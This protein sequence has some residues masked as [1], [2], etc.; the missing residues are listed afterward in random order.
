[1]L[2]D[3]S[4]RNLTLRQKFRI[5]FAVLVCVSLI[6]FLVLRYLGKIALF[7]HL[8][9]EHRVA[10]WQIRT[11]L[12]ALE[13]QTS[14]ARGVS[15]TQLL[16]RLESAGAVALRG[17]FQELL[18]IERIVLSAVR[19]AEFFERIATDIAIGERMM[20]VIRSEP[21][22]A[23]SVTTAQALNRQLNVRFENSDRFQPLLDQLVREFRVITFFVTALGLALLF[24]VG[25]LARR[26]ILNPVAEAVG[27]AA[28]VSDG[29][30]RANIEV[31]SADEIGQLQAALRKMTSGLAEL[32]HDV[33]ST[34]ASVAAAA[35]ELMAGSNNLSDR[36]QRQAHA[37]ER[38]AD[39]MEQLSEAV[40]MN[41]AHARRASETAER[42]SVLATEGSASVAK[43][44]E[45]MKAISSSSQRIA[46]I[47]AIMDSI[48][49]QTNILALNAAVEAARAGA[50]GRGFA[51]VAAEVRAL[52][53]RSSAAAREIK[54]LID[55]SSANVRIGNNL[56]AEAGTKIDVTADSIRQVSALVNDIS[57]ASEQQAGN[58][59][60][61]KQDVVQ[62]DSVAQQNAA[63][64]EQTAAAVAAQTEQARYLVDSVNR[65]KL[66]GE[67]AGATNA[68]M[69]GTPAALP[70]R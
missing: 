11:D 50:Q 35:R 70:R 39:R 29:D 56:V 24:W 57:A 55:T 32:V 12:N 40:R 2:N 54:Q 42:A 58:I 67:D 7:Y 3:L 65:F 1:V 45:T 23:I 19:Y 43:V 6:S 8:E 26:S 14:Q 47:I 27:I 9:R 10:L 36:T 13:H 25:S 44:I 51:V 17:G 48:S 18:D 64:V 60:Q 16:E 38:A 62:L 37:L 30:L 22:G 66:P 28:R 5:G 52:A 49:F 69:L 59:D 53:Q 63:L 41:V 21:G 61:I 33:R 68:P 31:R 46:D 20:A 34:S 15:R 4:L